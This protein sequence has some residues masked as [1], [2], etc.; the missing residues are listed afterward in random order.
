MT[1]LPY[2]GRNDDAPVAYAQRIDDRGTYDDNIEG[3][4]LPF[5][6]KLTNDGPNQFRNRL[7]REWESTEARSRIEAVERT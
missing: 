1:D 3:N 7:G 6:Y 4:E 5:V 2:L